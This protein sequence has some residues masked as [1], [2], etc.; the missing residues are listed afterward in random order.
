[1][2]AA[3]P[4]VIG[5]TPGRALFIILLEG[6]RE[7]AHNQV[8]I[9]VLNITGG[10]VDKGSRAIAGIGEYRRSQMRGGEPGG[11]YG[12]FSC[13]VNVDVPEYNIA[14]ASAVSDLNC[15]SLGIDDIDIFKGDIPDTGGGSFQ[16]NGTSFPIVTILAGTAINY[17]SIGE[18]HS[19][20][21]IKM[22]PPEYRIQP[23]GRA[24]EAVLDVVIL[25]PVSGTA[26]DSDCTRTP[27]IFNGIVQEGIVHCHGRIV[28]VVRPDRQSVI[29]VIAYAAIAYR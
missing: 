12:I 19:G 23:D 2:E 16:I 22:I 28:V 18:G 5:L 3:L 14:E 15:I 17:G 27:V 26:E 29:T 20:I 4:G 10:K 11:G 25:C 7:A 1:M 13:S 9:R 21:V 8:D 24:H 6:N